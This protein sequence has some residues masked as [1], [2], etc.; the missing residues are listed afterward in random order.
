MSRY[1]VTTES[2]NKIRVKNGE[3]LTVKSNTIR[4]SED[5]TKKI[6][7]IRISENKIFLDDPKTGSEIQF[8]L[9]EKYSDWQKPEDQ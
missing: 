4:N 5:E 7:E 9:G 3:Q 8:N 2:W 1:G 6:A